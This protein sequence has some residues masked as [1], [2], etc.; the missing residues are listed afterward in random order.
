MSAP[1]PD[2]LDALFGDGEPE[3]EPEPPGASTVRDIFGPD[4]APCP[5]E[6]VDTAE[7][8]ELDE[9][10]RTYLV[11]FYGREPSTAAM[12]C[13]QWFEHPEAVARLWALYLAWLTRCNLEDAEGDYTGPVVWQL[14][15]L[16]P[17][18]AQLRGPDGP[19]AGC[20]SH[21]GR[22]Q[23]TVPEPPTCRPLPAELAPH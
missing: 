7:L 17:T 1:S 9:W 20:T 21:P 19:F 13:E 8:A 5:P 14:E 6:F 3:S 12:W 22:H 18:L 10:L 15:Y 16:D 11:P 23:H 2:D 4:R